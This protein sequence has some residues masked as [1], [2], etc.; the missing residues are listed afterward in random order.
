MVF[1]QGN[2][3]MEGVSDRMIEEALKEISNESSVKKLGRKLN[4]TSPKPSTG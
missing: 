3:Y 1:E 4:I 2:Y